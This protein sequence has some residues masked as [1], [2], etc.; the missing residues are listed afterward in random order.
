MSDETE[1]VAVPSPDGAT[2]PTTP[3]GRGPI[4]SIESA[5]P[6]GYRL[7]E[8]ELIE[9]IGEG[10]FSIVYLA[11]DTQLQ[12]RVA[13]KEYI[14]AALACRAAD[15]HITIRSERHRDTFDL[16][17][18]SFINEGRI[19]ASFDH[20]S[21]IKVYRFWEQN[22]TAYMAMPFYAGPTLRTQRLAM[23]QAP[24][25][26]WIKRLLSPLLDALQ[27]IHAENIFHRD[28]APDN[29]LLLGAQQK[30]L[31]LDFGAAR[32]VIGDA[33][34]ALT[35]ILKPGYAPVE[36]YAELPSMKQGPWTDVYAL[37]AVL[38]MLITGR[39]PVASVARM[40][41]DELVPLEQVAAGRYGRSFLSAIDRGLA[42]RPEER[43][44]DIEALRSALFAVDGAGDDP[45]AT[46]IWPSTRPTGGGSAP[47]P[48]PFPDQPSGSPSTVPDDVTVVYRPP[49][50]PPPVSSGSGKSLVVGGLVVTVL[51]AGGAWVALRDRSPPA[52][53]APPPIASAAPPT[54]VIPATAPPPAAPP[55]GEFSVDAVLDEIAEHADSR[56]SVNVLADRDRVVIN[57]DH[58]RFRVKSSD[59][60][61]LYI[62]FRG[63]GGVELTLLFPNSLDQNNRI[64][65]D[66]EIVLPRKSWPIRADGP[67]GVD[68]I[69]TIVS[70]S[71]RD[72][73][74]AGLR[75]A[76]PMSSFDLDRLRSQW[77]TPTGGPSPYAG[78]ATCDSA[79]S[80]QPEFGATLLRISEVTR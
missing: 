2:P 28:I 54:T 63:T 46:R 25:E 18:R 32:R 50:T 9:V 66:K 70:R 45:E 56:I 60:G 74:D 67:A 39:A 8:F 12:R 15:D 24:D 59:A 65:A 23:E 80:C 11:Q 77:M 29:I 40:I 72:F 57:S 5:L 44:Q 16:G 51:A 34:Q 14:P 43:L 35:V 19:L 53:V 38:H 4:N 17:L 22:G 21:L 42:V 26:A 71:R 49:A 6:A 31:L 76:V 73:S 69:L 79:A 1:R 7:H 64:E 58:I 36:Q 13:V 37:C 61:Y 68:K 10:G 48:Q 33:T 41:R 20:P 52:V 27:I 55:R 3:A 78:T 75:P 30:P 47:P 62:L